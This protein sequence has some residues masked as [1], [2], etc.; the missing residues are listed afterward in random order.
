ME[1]KN[2][3]NKIL[4]DDTLYETNLTSS[5]INR[6]KY[7]PKNPKKV[8][9]VIPGLILDVFVKE[10][11]SVKD[12]DKLL[13]LEAMKMKNSITSPLNGK[14]KTVNVSQGES[15]PKGFLLIELE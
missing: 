6:K 12:G 3:L 11:Q 8:F 9:S 13:V 7:I 2:E 5:Y 15:V 4:I 1:E 10:G 14:I